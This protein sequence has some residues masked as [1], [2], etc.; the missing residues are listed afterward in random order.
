L[1]VLPEDLPLELTPFTF[2]IG[3]WSGTGVISYKQHLDQV[4]IEHEF[5]QTLEFSHNS[6]NFLTYRSEARLFGEE[7]PNLPTELGY[8][9][10]SKKAEASDSGPGLLPGQGSSEIKAR[11]DLEKLRNEAGGFDIEVSI[12]HPSGI[13]ELY[14]GQIKGARVDIATDAVLR[15]QSSKDYTA[16]RR[17]YGQVDGA[18]LW[19]W[20]MAALGMP[21][22]SHASA[23]LERVE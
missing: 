16:A 4:P 17:M 8:W 12:L 22:A 14:V 20:D 19:A 1:F 11:D 15:S 13:S 3:K 6:D 7:D 9:R 10:L 23:R 2:L 18:L 5:S 21:M